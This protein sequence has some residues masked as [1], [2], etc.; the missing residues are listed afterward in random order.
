MT[1]LTLWRQRKHEPIGSRAWLKNWAKR[2]FHAFGL[3]KICLRRWFLKR[4]GA[5]LGALTIVEATLEG[6]KRNFVA[7]DGCA[8]GRGKFALHA[9]VVIGNHVSI[10]EGVKLLTASHD[11]NDSEWKTFCKA[12]H[13]DDFAWIARDATVLPGVHI[14][15]G[16]VVGADA[17]VGRDVAP[18]T[19]VAG[20]PARP[21]GRQRVA[22]LCYTPSAFMAPFEAWLG[23]PTRTAGAAQGEQ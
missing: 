3:T 7:G 9:Q 13:I 23:R 22:E 10:N 19:V 21:T 1:L 8:I 4:A 15:R 2:A 11:L 14:G 12:I 16:A 18:Y 5:R 6:P 17:V 20:N